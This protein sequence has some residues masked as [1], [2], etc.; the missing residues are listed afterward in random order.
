MAA[1]PKI[2]DGNMDA[3]MALLKAPL[4]VPDR[5]QFVS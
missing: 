4:I 5:G 2:D 1:F 3:R